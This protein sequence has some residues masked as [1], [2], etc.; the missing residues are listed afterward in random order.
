MGCATQDEA[1]DGRLLLAGA[2]G[3]C[4]EPWLF[5]VR[6]FSSADDR[7]NPPWPTMSPAGSTAVSTTMTAV[8]DN[9]GA[10]VV[11]KGLL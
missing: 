9:L 5:G 11:A 4:K 10:T 1:D 6:T 7:G 2:A 3:V 8:G